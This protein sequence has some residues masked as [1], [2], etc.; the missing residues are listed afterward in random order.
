MPRVF[1]AGPVSWNQLIHVAQLPGRTA[2]ACV[3]SRELAAA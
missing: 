2:A 3:G 1:I